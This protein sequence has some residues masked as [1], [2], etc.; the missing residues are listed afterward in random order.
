MSNPA[1][2]PVEDQ[3]DTTSP[4]DS[5]EE[6][7]SRRVAGL[8]GR[9][10]LTGS[11][12]MLLAVFLMVV[13]PGFGFVEWFREYV[14]EELNLTWPLAVSLLAV[15]CVPFLVV[16]LLLIT[17]WLLHR[18]GM[19]LEL[20]LRDRSTALVRRAFATIALSVKVMTLLLIVA[21]GLALLW[22]LLWEPKG[23]FFYS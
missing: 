15:V 7:F 9:L 23:K 11:A 5:P 16:V 6:D 4:S 18:S 1:N 22:G 8:P 19:L 3:A 10:N 20:G 13:F 17:G 12:L 2:T 21:L 14:A